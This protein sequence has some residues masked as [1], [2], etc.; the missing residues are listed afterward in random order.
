MLYGI[1][2]DVTVYISG[3]IEAAQVS[4]EINAKN[5]K[6]AETLGKVNIIL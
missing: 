1:G 3:K 4:L 6:E 5:I 2:D